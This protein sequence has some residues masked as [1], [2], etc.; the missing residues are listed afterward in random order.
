MKKLQKLLLLLLVMSAVAPASAQLTAAKAFNEAPQSVFPLLDRNTRLDMIDYFNAGLKH[1]SVN[2]LD[3]GSIITALS[4][5]SMT[6]KMTDASRVQ[7]FVVP[8]KNDTVIGVITTVATPVADSQLKLY[9]RRWKPLDPR[10]SFVAPLLADW[11]IDRGRQAEVEIEVPF[12]LVGYEF[13]P[14]TA[15]LTLV[16]NLGGFLSD[17]LFARLS[18]LMHKQLRYRW[19]GSR[20]TLMK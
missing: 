5:E 1:E 9:S 18:P 12:M 19:D 13:D 3:G 20:F 15:T 4:P 17:D 10:K 14:A 16:N 8:A 7:L 6:I 2:A 11:M